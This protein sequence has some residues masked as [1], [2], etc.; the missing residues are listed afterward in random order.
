MVLLL[1]R[2]LAT[3]QHSSS[4]CDCQEASVLGS[5]SQKAS[6]SESPF[7]FH[8]GSDTRC[9]VGETY[10]RIVHRSSVDH[11]WPACLTEL[12]L[13]RS[14]CSCYCNQPHQARL[15]RERGKVALWSFEFVCF[16][17]RQGLAGIR[18]KRR[19]QKASVCWLQRWLGCAVPS[20]C[21]FQGSG[22][23][24]ARSCGGQQAIESGIE[25]LDKCTARSGALN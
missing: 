4:A 17:S 9:V 25:S 3:T 23:H 8:H 18:N 15:R 6:V 20:I 10:C 16:R 12:W 11:Q 1:K 7:G 14:V 24:P 21:H 5:A 19:F 22:D 2:D 13:C